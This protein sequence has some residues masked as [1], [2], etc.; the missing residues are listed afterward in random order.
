MN[1]RINP[2]HNALKS[3]VRANFSSNTTGKKPLSADKQQIEYPNLPS[4][5]G[6]F[7]KQ[8]L[9]NLRKN[10]SSTP[11]TAIRT[12]IMPPVVEESWNNVAKIEKRLAS[13]R[14]RAQNLTD[15]M[16]AKT[17]KIVDLYANGGKTSDGRQIA[18][19][20]DD[21]CEGLKGLMQY[22]EWPAGLEEGTIKTFCTFIEGRPYKIEEFRADG[23]KNIISFSMRGVPDKYQKGFNTIGARHYTADRELQINEYT[24]KVIKYAENAE[25]S[26]N[27]YN[28]FTVELYQAV[29]G[30]GELKTYI[31]DY[32]KSQSGSIQ[33][34]EM[35]KNKPYGYS[36]SITTYTKG[37]TETPGENIKATSEKEMIY[38][39]GTPF[40]YFEDVSYLLFGERKYAL[41]YIYTNDRWVES[42]EV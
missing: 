8:N 3:G 27:G 5:T 36:D 41:G 22:M 30:T 34:K 13:T 10:T 37:Y 35:L 24:K 16:F 28:S 42:C 21:K 40:S 14:K 23:K 29:T 19:I 9:Y 15:E 31:E 6:I 18:K 4:F 26:Q 39:D 33:I 38:K 32:K 25:F 7:G 17:D 12:A 1:L 2:Y 11:T 20:I